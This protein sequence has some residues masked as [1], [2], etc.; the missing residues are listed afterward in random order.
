MDTYIDIQSVHLTNEE[1]TE[2]CSWDSHSIPG[3]HGK[4]P[5]GG[6]KKKSVL[7][8]HGLK[9]NEQKQRTR[10]GYL[11]FVTLL[12]FLAQLTVYVTVVL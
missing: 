5:R 11:L 1:T 10:D 3:H 12:Q 6:Q 7:Y 9:K 2:H 8:E 4:Q